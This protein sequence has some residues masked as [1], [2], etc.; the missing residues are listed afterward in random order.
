MKGEAL[1][2]LVNIREK[3]Q[4]RFGKAADKR[5]GDR[6]KRD[7]LCLELWQEIVDELN[8]LPESQRGPVWTAA[9]AQSCHE[10]HV[11]KEKKFVA[12]NSGKSGDGGNSSLAVAIA[13]GSGSDPLCFHPRIIES[14][15]TTQNNVR[16]ISQKNKR[17]T[18]IEVPSVL[19]D[20][21]RGA[22]EPGSTLI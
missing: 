15:M 19:V 10:R 11:R 12:D 18:E 20:M 1:Y 9:Q 5:H 7:K 6:K 3:L 22:Y 13:N 21:T 14:L 2:A 8:S 16:T 17:R 4:A